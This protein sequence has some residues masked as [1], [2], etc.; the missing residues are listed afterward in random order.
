[1]SLPAI[2]AILAVLLAVL[3]LIVPDGRRAGWVLAAAVIVLSVA[4]LLHAGG[5]RLG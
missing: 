5:V 2:L 1:M 4:E 3:A